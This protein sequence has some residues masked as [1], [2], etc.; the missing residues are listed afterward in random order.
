MRSR[1]FVGPA[2]ILSR[3]IHLPLESLF[4]NW[5][6]GI[7][8]NF[9]VLDLSW[10]TVGIW[11]H[12]IFLGADTFR[13]ESYYFNQKCMPKRLFLYGPIV[14]IIPTLLKW[15]SSRHINP[16]K[17]LISIYNWLYD[18]PLSTLYWQWLIFL[19]L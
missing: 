6:L 17:K 7:A 3:S 5:D 2:M 16:F 12:L 19:V 4:K 14:K 10:R 8:P 13:S 15:L 18:C 11:Q 9:K 1:E